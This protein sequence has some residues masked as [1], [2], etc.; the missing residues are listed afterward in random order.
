[1]LYL[2]PF[3]LPA[4]FP[5]LLSFPI[6][7]STT[8]FYRGMVPVW[9]I[10]GRT[11]TGERGQDSS[12]VTAMLAE[13]LGVLRQACWFRAWAKEHYHIMLRKK[14]KMAEALF[15]SPR[16]KYNKDFMLYNLSMFQVRSESRHRKGDINQ[17]QQCNHLP[18]RWKDGRSSVLHKTFLE[19]CS[20][21][22]WP[23]SPKQLK[24]METS[25]KTVKKQPKNLKWLHIVCLR[26]SKSSR[27]PEI[28]N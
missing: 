26:S 1:M 20:K 2:V 10:T 6:L 22:A 12:R 5:F 4:F 19:L 9:Y 14:K 24:Q 15:L 7:M 11:H 8:A 3:A 16:W 25:F 17:T 18:C 23:Y 28:L 21:T 13:R 27:S